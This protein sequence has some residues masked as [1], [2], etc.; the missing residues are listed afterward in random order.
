MFTILNQSADPP[1]NNQFGDASNAIS[2]VVKTNI[3]LFA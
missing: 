2:T 3:I 1:P